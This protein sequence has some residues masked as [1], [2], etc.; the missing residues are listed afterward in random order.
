[1]QRYG[2]Q[3]LEYYRNRAAQRL[4]GLDMLDALNL[5]GSYVLDIGALFGF[6]GWYCEQ[7]GAQ[8]ILLD[9]FGE[10]FPPFLSRKIIGSK[11]DIPL[12]DSSVDFVVCQDVLHHGDLGQTAREIHRVLKPGGHFLSVKEP[13]ISSKEDEQAILLR[14]CKRE[15]ESGIQE[16]RPNL[17]EYQGAFT[18]SFGSSPEVRDGYNLAIA[19]DKNY[20]GHGIIIHA[21]KDKV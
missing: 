18:E 5:K 1:M 10:A 21:V 8:A 20:G 4:K 9:I 6:L 14:D 15:L 17:L 7:Q 2:P 12:Y 3:S 16:R 11:E 19:K 13:C